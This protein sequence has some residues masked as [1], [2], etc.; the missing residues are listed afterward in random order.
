MVA[1]VDAVTPSSQSTS[2]SR[3]ERTVVFTDIVESTNLKQTLGDTRS[4]VLFEQHDA[5]IRGLLGEYPGA[6]ELSVAGDSFTLSFVSAADALVFSLRLHAALEKLGTEEGVVL[7][8][9]V[10]IH[11]GELFVDENVHSGRPIGGMAL[12][13]C[14]RIMS[15][16]DGGQ[17]LLSRVSFDESRRAL[18]QPDS[19]W[20]GL[21]EWLS[22]GLYQLKGAEEPLEVFE[23]GLPGHAPLKAPAHAEKARRLST[24][25]GELVLGWRPAVGRDVPGTSWK[26]ERPL[27]EGGFGE[28]WLGKHTV[29]KERRVFKGKVEAESVR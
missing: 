28:V 16:A 12:D 9:R 29:L 26:L 22:H 5:A 14:A 27:G 7:R 8:V 19:A 13:V 17:T 11:T 18:T 25:D 24:P 10:G 2:R 4:I 3:E 23:V 15:L 21:H 20:L 6:K 1:P